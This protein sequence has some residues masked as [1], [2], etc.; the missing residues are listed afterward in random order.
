MALLALSGDARPSPE[1][2]QRAV[3]AAIVMLGT[4]GEKIDADLLTREV[5]RLTAITQDQS[6]GPSSAQ[7]HK[8]W[9]RDAKTELSWD[10][11][12]RYRWYLEEDRGLPPNVVRRLHQSTDDVLEQLED[13]RRHG[14]WRRTGLVIGQVQ[15][16]KTGH[17]IGLAAKAIDAGYRLV[18][19]MAG[20]HNDLRSQTQLRVDEGLLGFHTDDKKRFS[21]DGDPARIGA[22]RMRSE[23]KYPIGTATDSSEKGDFSAK[24]ANMMRNLPGLGD[25]PL[26]LVIKKHQQ[27]LDALREWVTD[28]KGTDN[29]EGLRIVRD[30]PLFVIDDEADNAS[31]NTA[32]TDADPTRINSAIRQLMNSFDKAAYVGYTATPF[33]NIYIDPKS[34]DDRIGADLFPESFIRSIPP[35]SNYFG[36]ERVFGLQADDDDDDVAPLP[37]SRKVNDV[38]RWLPSDHKQHHLPDDNLP[39]SLQEAVR[40]FAL[41]CAARRVRGQ[42][43]VHNS[44][45]VHVTRFV[46]VQLAVQ[47]HL[48][49]YVDYL[50]DALRDRYGQRQRL[51][52]EFQ[53]LWTRD[54][55]PT[56]HHF[57]EDVA[58]RVSW[59][60]VCSELLPALDKIQVRAVNGAARDALDYYEHRSG[61]FSVIAVGGQKLSRGL[62]LEGLTV[63]YYLRYSKTY[64]T[65]LQMGRWFGYRPGYE[66]LCRL[67]TSSELL[68]QYVE[69][70]AATNELRREV[71]EMAELNLT[72][73]DFGLKVRA[74]SS[75]VLRVTAANKMRNA[76]R[77][78][79]SFSGAGPETVIFNLSAEARRANL[80]ALE[81]LVR[82]LNAGR[83]HEQKQP[84]ATV[85][86]KGV[87][88]E[89][90]SGF[91]QRYKRDRM[92]KLT[93]PAHIATYIDNCAR[94][95]ELQTWAVR[96]VGNAAM[97]HVKICGHTVGLV[98]RTALNKDEEAQRYTVRRVVSPADEARDLDPSQV[99]AALDASVKAAVAKGRKPPQRASGEHLRL[100]RRPDQALL[101]VYLV[102]PQHLDVLDSRP[103]LVGFQLSFPHSPHRRGTEYVANSVWQSDNLAFDDEEDD[104]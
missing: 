39:G 95:G 102:E 49:D 20:I 18:V 97:P 103:P 1:K 80:D 78:L 72:P 88:P 81:D 54:F 40:A 90:V 42:R 32:V 7:G 30:L 28:A 64:D 2:V 10:F 35:P 73:K 34:D 46:R 53:Q 85:T 94:A 22:G 24:T 92:A 55:E 96:M 67:Y 61:G 11:W 19:I 36:P 6:S 98:K 100:Q 37:L 63:S 60:D 101:L 99:E 69:V 65:L 71:E 45:L 104:E 76:S 27:K 48:K 5:E 17:Y 91:L 26:V 9:L 14:P 50:C 43:Q 12:D 68:D 87:T 25:F 57:R 79:L 29:G 23:R 41:A 51:L 74:S 38:E 70:T 33:A 31:I 58:Q 13:P 15:S 77:I 62:T 75:R 66:D 83:A 84:G 89:L 8:P 3:R 82:R 4:M 86:W 93:V 16:G 21:W 44:M 47:E 52:S 59:R 56:T